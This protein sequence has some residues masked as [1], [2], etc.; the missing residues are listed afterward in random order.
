MTK[1]SLSE[2]KSIMKFVVI[3]MP[4]TE[5]K[6]SLDF[7]N[8]RLFRRLLSPSTLSSLII[9]GMHLKLACYRF[10]ASRH[11]D[12]ITARNEKF[13]RKKLFLTKILANKCGEN[14]RDGALCHR[15]SRAISR[16]WDRSTWEISP[17]APP[18]RRKRGFFTVAS[19]LW[20]SNAL[21]FDSF[22]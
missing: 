20:F 14:C 11:R 10:C 18:P 17:G 6:L 13:G 2:A 16:E 8:G 3:V 21:G 15:S 1:T 19:D 7:S 12:R 4:T 22:D 5:M 9:V